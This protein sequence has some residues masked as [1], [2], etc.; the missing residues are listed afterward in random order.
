MIT[1]ALRKALIVGISDYTHL[2]A[3]DI[4]KNDGTEVYKVLVTRI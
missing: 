2:Q 1:G 3:L 4:C